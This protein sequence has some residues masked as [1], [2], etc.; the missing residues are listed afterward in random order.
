[1]TSGQCASSS[2][3]C[4]A[5]A[6]ARGTLG[7]LVGNIPKLIIAI[8]RMRLNWRVTRLHRGGQF[9]GDR[10]RFA[11]LLAVALEGEADGIRM[12]H[13]ASE[14]FADECPH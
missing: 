14:R 10:R 11:A 3:R 8:E 12:W 5:T 7:S 2:C 1:M 9:D 6:R 4:S 13:A